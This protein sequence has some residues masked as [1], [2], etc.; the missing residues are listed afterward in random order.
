V[1]FGIS[2]ALLCR[3]ALFDAVRATPWYEY[4]WPAY[5][6]MVVAWLLTLR[7]SL[8]EQQTIEDVE[9]ESQLF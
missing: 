1:I 6:M 9:A 3:D 8:I 7:A 4:L 5:T 2:A